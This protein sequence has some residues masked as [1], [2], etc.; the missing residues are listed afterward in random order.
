M[1]HERWTLQE[2][3]APKSIAF[4]DRDWRDLGSRTQLDPAIATITS[5]EPGV[6]DSTSKLKRVSVAEKMSWAAGRQT[7]RE[8]DMAYSLL[9]L[10]EVNMPLLYGE[11]ADRAFR[12]LQLAIMQGSDD[13][14]ILAWD[15]SEFQAPEIRMQS[16]K[17]ALASSPN[18]FR[19]KG[20]WRVLNYQQRRAYT[21]TNKGLV[22]LATKKCQKHVPSFRTLVRQCLYAG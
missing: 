19:S 16:L 17:G 9:G 11:G 12:R 1:V 13:E 8:E 2:L 15:D 5:I 3:I 10:F 22:S 7:T 4:L 21:M 6:C 20:D 18:A 14:T